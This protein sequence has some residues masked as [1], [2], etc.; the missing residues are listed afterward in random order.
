MSGCEEVGE[1]K[2]SG[3]ISGQ[4]FNAV[5][6]I[7]KLSKKTTRTHRLLLRNK[8]MDLPVYEIPV[9]FLFFSIING[10]YADRMIRLKAEFPDIE[11]DPRDPDMRDK[12]QE[13]LMGRGNLADMRDK[14]SS[15]R[16][17]EDIKDKTQIVPGIIAHDGG[18]LDGNRRLAVLIELG[19]EHLDGVILPEDTSD[20]DKW[21]I[22]AGQQMSKPLIQTFSPMNEL[23][24]I[25]EGVQLFRKMKAEGND[26]APKK[27]PEDLVAETLYGRDRKEI[28]EMLRRLALIEEY[29]RWLKKPNRFDL[30]GDRAE[31]FKEINTIIEDAKNAEVSPAELYK[32]KAW[33]FANAFT[34]NV[35]NW[36]FRE[37]RRA[38]P[39][40]QKTGRSI[41][42][43]KKAQMRLNDSPLDPDKL[44]EEC[45]EMD[46]NGK[47]FEE[48]SEGKKDSEVKKAMDLAEE[49]IDIV[50]DEQK[51]PDP[52]RLIN[53]IK[54]KLENLQELLSTATEEKT[55]KS[56]KKGL[57]DI[58]SLVKDALEDL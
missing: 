38:I 35:N 10:R 19:W 5:A 24:K 11:P 2:S 1:K 43:S 55:K 36:D 44:R 23:L 31:R 7:Q 46:R 39:G 57:N 40:R 21:R 58:L 47:S 28:D 50:R 14:E 26:P 52:M 53:E 22:E 33:L 30:I 41:T 45:I 49:V 16:L 34:K 29:L 18:V 56:L 15:T 20:E 3:R 17:L 12:I 25:R 9:K 27:T 51:S 32:I 42:K 4:K 54:V 6:D 37:V 8:P 48:T 13:L